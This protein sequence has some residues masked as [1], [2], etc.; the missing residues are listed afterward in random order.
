MTVNQVLCENEPIHLVG[1]IQGFGKFIV[2]DDNHQIIGISENTQSWLNTTNPASYLGQSISE[3]FN[4]FDQENKAILGDLLKKLPHLS[5]EKEIAQTTIFGDSYVVRA[6]RVNSLLYIE[7][8]NSDNE[9]QDALQLPSYS[10]A[11]NQAEDRVWEALSASIRDIIG[12]DRVMV[13]QFLE[14]ASGQVIAE[15][16]REDITSYFGFRFPEFDIPKQAR[17]LYLKNHARQTSNIDAE[18]YAILSKTS[19]AFD[20]TDCDLRAL[21]PIHLQYLKNGGAQASMSFSII[22]QG[23]LWGL[24]ACQHGEALHVDYHK[25]SLALFLTEFAVN[26][27]LTMARERDLEFDRQIASLELKLK[28]QLL[29][30][31]D[32]F[33]ALR[34]HLPQLAQ[35]LNA[36]GLAIVD[37]DRILLYRTLIMD[38]EMIELHHFVSNKTGKLLFED[39]RFT[40][41]YEDEIAFPIPFAGLVRVD[42]D[43]SRTFSI[44]A[45]RNEVVVEEEWAGNPEKIMQYDAGENLFRP[46][47][48]Q[49]FDAWKKQI[50]GTAPAWTNDE[51]FALKRI[52]QIV[53]ES[54]LRKSEEI[55]SLNQELI[56]LNNALDTY[57]Y[58]V[59][60]DL[61]NPLASIKL[62]GQFLQLKLGKENDLAARS[63]AN[64]LDAVDVMEN[65]MEKILEFSRAKVYQYTPEWVDVSTSI[66]KIVT[67]YSDRFQMDPINIEIKNLL[68]VYG[69]KTLFHQ[70]FAN[71]VGNAIKY[72]SKTQNPKICIESQIRNDNIQYTIRDNGI[73]IDVSELAHIYDVFK[74][75]SNS[76]S[77]E[78]S[79]VGMAIVKRIIE[80][81]NASIEVESEIGKG[82][83]VH[84]TFP[85]AEIPVELLSHST[86]A[87]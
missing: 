13:Y 73:G 28:E 71:I 20:L 52:R 54:M 55:N 76:G 82:T 41:K 2:L 38:G 39:H 14:D 33:T 72:S 80:R 61:R 24:V 15:S 56:Q 16:K 46:S 64:I 12:Y 31:N 5:T 23:K 87:G 67:E 43:L 17:A 62:T 37:K 35:L 60:H 48:R 75:M 7:F 81:L 78:G 26:K 85:N 27:H 4:Q 25:R 3:L 69:E 51:L 10:K 68:P 1:K 6:Y 58:T 21:S 83:T 19:D 42:I 36:D 66:R 32:V 11:L 65:L 30:K 86:K 84:L 34:A 50:H 70:V 63:A 18:T 29:I 59:T 53:R 47:P 40:I 57:S 74:R 9:H 44:Y 8:E 79:G 77:F 49:S 22:V 45:F